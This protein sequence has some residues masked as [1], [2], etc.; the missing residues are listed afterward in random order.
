MVDLHPT[1]VVGKGA[2]LDEHVKI[3]PYCVVGPEVELGEGVELVS[4]VVVAGRTTIGS[5]TRV[6]SFASLGNPPQDLKYKGEPTRLAIG[7]NNIVREHATM[8]PGTAGGG[9]LTQVGDNGL[10]MIGIHIAHDC[11]VG[12][13]V[14]MANNATL[15][16]HVQVGDYAVLGGLS[17]VH[18]YVR[19]G[20]H[21]MIGG[22]S[23]VEG[24][25]IPFGSVM[26]ERARLS[27]LNVV[28]LKRR[29]FSRDDIHALRTAYRILFAQEGTIAERLEDVAELYSVSRPVM[30]LVDFIRAESQRPI[31]QPKGNRDA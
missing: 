3:G 24:D 19:I 7:R 5:G 2:R 16:G 14:V 17:A 21:A 20:H 25:V 18:Q 31:V 4:H 22:M 13:G 29:G 1:A 12:D 10:F 26:G 27:G 11:K 15:G 28:G 8:N 6:Y 23:G 9:G 30:D